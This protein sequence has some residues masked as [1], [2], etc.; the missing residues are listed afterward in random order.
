MTCPYCFRCTGPTGMY[1]NMCRRL[2]ERMFPGRFQ[3]WSEADHT[4]RRRAGQTLLTWD[5]QTTIWAHNDAWEHVWDGDWTMDEAKAHIAAL[6]PLPPASVLGHMLRTLA[7]GKT[8]RAVVVD[9]APQYTPDQEA[10]AMSIVG[11]ITPEL[12][13]AE[14]ERI[15]GRPVS[16]ERMREIE[17]TLGGLYGEAAA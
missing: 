8:A 2:R 16:P 17:R 13:A 10:F 4:A 12:M 9:R 1:E 14:E 15:T 11:K 7:N 5:Q 6:D 3:R